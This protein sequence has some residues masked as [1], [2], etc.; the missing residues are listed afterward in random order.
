MLRI[1]SLESIAL[2]GVGHELVDDA[3][4]QVRVADVYVLSYED[5]AEKRIGKPEGK[6]RHVTTIDDRHE[7]QMVDFE[8]IF[9]ISHSD[10]RILKLIC[11]KRDF[12]PSTY[13]TLR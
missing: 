7:R 13:Q 12:M 2:G 1:D 4:G 10:S 9:H 5:L 6:E 11:Q 3:C 8:A